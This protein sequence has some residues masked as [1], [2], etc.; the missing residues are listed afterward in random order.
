[1]NPYFLDTVQKLG[2]RS[3]ARHASES[4]RAHLFSGRGMARFWNFQISD[5]K[6]PEVAYQIRYM[7]KESP[8][9]KELLIVEI[10]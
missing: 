7:C 5:F 10:R 3:G 2:I 6:A 9:G 4:A 8:D 1:M